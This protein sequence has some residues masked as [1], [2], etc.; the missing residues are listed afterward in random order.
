MDPIEA[1]N[2]RRIEFAEEDA[3]QRDEKIL[4]DNQ[5]MFPECVRLQLFNFLMHISHVTLFVNLK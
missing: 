2:Y 1:P 3:L 4:M 5:K